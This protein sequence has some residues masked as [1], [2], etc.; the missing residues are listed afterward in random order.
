MD[1][2]NLDVLMLQNVQLFRKDLALGQRDVSN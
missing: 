1:T 2:P